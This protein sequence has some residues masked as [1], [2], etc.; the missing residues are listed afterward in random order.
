[1]KEIEETKGFRKRNVAR[2]TQ[3]AMKK[4]DWA[5]QS[6]QINEVRAMSLILQPE[7]KFFYAQVRHLPA[8][9]AARGGTLQGDP[10]QLPNLTPTYP[11]VP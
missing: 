2:I 8:D 10:T 9:T 4:R 1:M 6:S 7:R 5:S 11:S 3:S